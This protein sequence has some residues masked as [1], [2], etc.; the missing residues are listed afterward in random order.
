MK[1]NNPNVLFLVFFIT[2]APH[3]L[4]YKK[5]PLGAMHYGIDTAM[6]LLFGGQYCYLVFLLFVSFL[7]CFFVKWGPD[8]IHPIHYLAFYLFSHVLVC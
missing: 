1:K 8:V 4:L 5:I 6:H 7:F 3:D 2:I